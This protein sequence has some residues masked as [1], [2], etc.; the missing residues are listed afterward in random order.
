[1]SNEVTIQFQD[2]IID[3]NDLYNGLGD[4][5]NFTLFGPD[6]SELKNSSIYLK[7]GNYYLEA[8]FWNE[9]SQSYNV[10]FDSIYDLILYSENIFDNYLYANYELDW[11]LN[12]N[13]EGDDYYAFAKHA[14]QDD[15]LVLTYYLQQERTAFMNIIDKDMFRLPVLILNIISMEAILEFI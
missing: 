6:G 11:D 4:L 10:T 8:T 14:S 13:A 9:T 5:V 15:P 2:N 1:M 12:W 7:S 3:V